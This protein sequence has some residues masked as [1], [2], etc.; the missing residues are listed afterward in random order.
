MPSSAEPDRRWRAVRT[1]LLRHAG[2]PVSD[3]AGLA[4]PEL[5]DTAQRLLAAWRDLADAAGGL[6]AALRTYRPGDTGAVGSAVGALKPLPAGSS[7]VLDVLPDAPVRRY[8]AAVVALE[9]LI[10]AVEQGHGA[11]VAT[12]RR[13]VRDLFADP[14]RQ[15]VLLLS[16]DTVA[17]QVGQWSS[18]D[19]GGG[20]RDR[21]LTDLLTMYLQR[22]TTKNETNAHFGPFALGR[23]DEQVTGV[24]WAQRGAPRRFVHLAH[25]A[26]S[27]LLA[28]GDPDAGRVRPRPDPMVFPDGNALVRFGYADAPGLPYPWWLTGPDR[29]SLTPAQRWL[30]AQ[31][32]G[33]VTVAGLRDRWRSR[34]DPDG[35]DP[36]W[37]VLRS[38]RLVIDVA[39]LPAGDADT[40]GRLRAALTDV[41]GDPAPAD[42]VGELLDRFATGRPEHRVT[43]LEQL[44]GLYSGLTG[45]PATRASGA[46]YADR[47]VLFEE[48]LGPVADVVAG[49]EVTRFVE[50]ELAEVYDSML[51]GSRLRMVRERDILARWLA[52]VFGTGRS[53]P[54][55]AVHERFLADRA[56]VAAWCD[57]VDAEVA[58][59]ERDFAAALLRGWDGRAARHDLP[60]GT[61][62]DLLAGG[63]AQPAA[64]CNPDVMLGAESAEAFGR[65]EFFGVVGDCHAVR[66]LLTHGPFAP[67]LARY[68][69]EVAAEVLDGYRRIVAQDETLVEVV[70]AHS[71]K[72]SA[73]MELPLPRLEVAGRAPGPRSGVL[74]PRDLHLTVRDGRVDLVSPRLPGRLRLMAS[75][76]GAASIRH[77]PTAV[78]SFPR[79]LGGGVLSSLDLPYLPR[80]VTGR[81]VL[82][83]RRWRV[84]VA[85]LDTWRPPR[86]LAATDARGFVSATLLWQRLG[87]PRHVFVKFPQEPKPVYVDW[88][89]PLL[90]RQFHRLLRGAGADGVAEISEM[91]P[92]PDQ[93]WLRVD[94]AARTAELRCTVFSR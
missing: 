8:R 38:H 65:G 43:A 37:A 91:L 86:R 19:T 79:S 60:A 21:K 76:S 51:L 64:L 29:V 53:V 26:A 1:V 72:V 17:A 84:P 46:H 85:E 67:V 36:A 70:R 15:Q 80:I 75:V 11:T 48:C 16:N 69:P 42:R 44:K 13:R 2:Y 6:K 12:S 33:E 25:W 28:A 40:V 87:L 45:T 83:R 93:L 74:L 81:V 18:G 66:D 39:E 89:A 88:T 63:P 10:S 34:Y 22:I 5:A 14:W 52:D 82:T 71:S 35:F 90:V 3:L 77:D 47:A 23:L 62:R 20:A 94:G 55:G 78:F 32:D 30:F 73:Q 92:G 41:A 9:E 57:A 50:T 61:V 59:A 68:A 4:D 7:A 54:L 31:V 56:Q 27:A 24:R 58:A 49:R